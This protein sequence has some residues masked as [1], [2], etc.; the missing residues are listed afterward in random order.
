MMPGQRQPPRQQQQTQQQQQILQQGTSQHM[1]AQQGAPVPPRPQEQ[2]HR[3]PHPASPLNTV[4]G[5]AH[6]GQT[7]PMNGVSSP[8]HVGLI[9]M[10]PEASLSIGHGLWRISQYE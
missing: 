9:A 4:C 3:Q 1:P 10:P 2:Q 8:S 7:S 6:E 5:A